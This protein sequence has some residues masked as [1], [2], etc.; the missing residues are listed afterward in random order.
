MSPADPD[1]LVIGRF[2]RLIGL[3]VGA[4]RHYDELDILRPAW[5]DPET[6][7]RSYRRDQLETARTITRLRD[8]EMPLEGIRAFMA[9]DDPTERRRLM[10]DHRG[11][12]EARTLRL[13][14]V[15]HAVSRLAA[16]PA[17]DTEPTHAKEAPTMT[18]PTADALTELDGATHR[19]LGVALFNYVWTLLEK[20]DRTP[21]ET[22]EMIH[23]AH[24]SRFHWSRATGT[25]PVNLARGEWQCSRVYAVLGRGE[26]ALWHARRCLA[27]N[28]ANGQGDW[29]IASAY[30]AMARAHAVAGERDEA[31]AWKAKAV[32]ALE[33]IA[34]QDDR[35]I[36]EGDIATLP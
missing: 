3:S 7:Y 12:I 2:A 19:A 5:V 27:I 34:E 36:I 8:L 28:E 18:T 11:R 24:A 1:L 21:A 30:E 35:Q 20:A 9:S 14:Y 29:D 33:G 16:D 22:D 13:Q 15:L 17:D 4:L 6:G 31:V 32:A 25:E 26:P 23:A 10:T